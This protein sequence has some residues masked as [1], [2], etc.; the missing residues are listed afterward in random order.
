MCKCDKY[1][2]VK[3]A[4]TPMNIFLILNTTNDETNTIPLINF[5]QAF[6]YWK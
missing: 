6:P 3:M 1:G 4:Q 2:S 5:H